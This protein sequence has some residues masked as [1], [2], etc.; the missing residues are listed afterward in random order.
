MEENYKVSK[1]VRRRTEIEI[2]SI[3]GCNYVYPHFELYEGS[4]LSTDKLMLISKDVFGMNNPD[5]I[6]MI[7]IV[8]NNG[9]S[10]IALGRWNDGVIYSDKK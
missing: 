5:S 3:L 10:Y 4:I 9:N 7:K 1:N 6:D 8:T 2:I